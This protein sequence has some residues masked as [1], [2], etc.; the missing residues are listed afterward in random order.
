[1]QISWLANSMFARLTSQRRSIA[2][3]DIHKTGRKC[4]QTDRHMN[5]HLLK[6]LLSNTVISLNSKYFWWPLGYSILKYFWCSY[7]LQLKKDLTHLGIY[8]YYN[9]TVSNSKKVSMSGFLKETQRKKYRK[10]YTIFQSCF[11]NIL[12]NI[13]QQKSI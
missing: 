3:K 2:N 9:H 4:R 1:M 10:S 5:A 8:L 12:S 11:A 7:Y 6:S 13:I